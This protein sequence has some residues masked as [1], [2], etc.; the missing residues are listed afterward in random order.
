MSSSAAEQ[1]HDDDAPAVAGPGQRL[2][3]WLWFV[4]V[5][6][7]RTQAAGLVTDGKVRINRVRVEKPSQ[8][9]RPAQESMR[10]LSDIVYR[11]VGVLMKDRVTSPR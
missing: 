10:G 1:E 8:T 9:V 7:T 4:R 3:K 2:D 6:K 5:I 11:A